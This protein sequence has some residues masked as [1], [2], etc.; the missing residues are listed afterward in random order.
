[1]RRLRLLLLIAAVG[2]LSLLATALVLRLP[3]A[4]ALAGNADVLYL[5]A[6]F[7]DLHRGLDALRGWH[8][9]PGPYVFPDMAIYGLADLATGDFRQALPLAAALQL[10]LLL[11]LGGAVHR[12]AGGR[13]AAMAVAAFAAVLALLF[14]FGWGLAGAYALNWLIYPFVVTFHFGAILI[15][16][17]V[18]LLVLRQLDRP[19]PWPLIGLAL[20][21][22]AGVLSDS[23]VLPYAAAP[24]LAL[25]CTLA[26]RTRRAASAAVAAVG[27]AALAAFLLQGWINPLGGIYRDQ[28]DLGIGYGLFR[29]GS[30]L[31][32]ANPAELAVNFGLIVFAL[33]PVARTVAV[34][35][36][37][38]AGNREIE[39][40]DRIAVFAA[41]SSLATLL[42]V[43]LF[44]IFRDDS[45]LRYFQPWLFLTA[46][47]LAHL[48][49]DRLR[50]PAWP[51]GATV[52]VL[53]AVAAALWARPDQLAARI[54][55][56]PTLA[57]FQGSTAGL[58]GY[59]WA[60][61]LVLHSGRRVQIAQIAR[62]GA[63]YHWIINEDWA[64]RD[65]AGGTGAPPFGFILMDGL[66]ARA[67]MA[68]YG[69]PDRVEHCA[70]IPLWRYDDPDR[71]RR[72]LAAATP[73]TLPD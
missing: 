32:R 5:P 19:G 36:G 3:G 60:K 58:A 62:N 67:V 65:W 28:L 10:G 30:V 45:F 66:H 4:A 47:W 24:A 44:G 35:R 59:W 70:G 8:L 25:L 61:P 9:T 26:P 15:A 11:L 27:A 63:P 34:L 18:L 22:L 42:A 2:G 52:A 7:D 46:L 50:V 29:L 68:R 56:P 69:M 37:L 12:A 40:A 72:P 51:V 49:A 13:S 23:F 16:A 1:M 6:L 73:V 31:W 71:L 20:L 38:A 17:A 57:C 53:L 55:P 21:I 14:A 64:R 41:A 39:P 54:E 43:V 33:L 48:A